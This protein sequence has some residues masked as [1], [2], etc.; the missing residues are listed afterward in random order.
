MN[1]KRILVLL[2]VIVS[3]GC[4][5]EEKELPLGTT[6]NGDINLPDSCIAELAISSEQYQA[7]IEDI[8]PAIDELNLEGDCLTIRFSE[9]GCDGTSWEVN[10]V[11]LTIVLESNP[12]QRTVRLVL[13]N[14][15]LCDAVIKQEKTFDLSPLRTSGNQV[16][17]NIENSDDRILYQY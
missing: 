4:H 8:L 6:D 5:K 7:E 15:E 13:K 17:I 16:I 14:E 12:P 10:L 9:S 3:I 11:Y 1:M 2:F